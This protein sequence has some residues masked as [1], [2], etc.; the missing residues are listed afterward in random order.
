MG[1]D[2]TNWIKDR[3]A[4]Y[5]FSEGSDFI[6]VLANSGENPWGGRPSTEYHLSLDM[7]KE[8]SMVERNEKGKHRRPPWPCR[9]PVH[10][11]RPATMR[12]SRGPLRLTPPIAP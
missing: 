2:F 4:K 12:I 3:I 10:P 9:G 5:G 6:K 11:A 7:A 8:L 1:R